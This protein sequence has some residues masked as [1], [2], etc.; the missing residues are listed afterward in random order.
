MED[1]GGRVVSL[2]PNKKD[3]PGIIQACQ[4]SRYEARK[5]FNF[6]IAR[7]GL[8]KLYRFLDVTND[9]L[10]LLNTRLSTVVLEEM[11]LSKG[12]Q[13]C[14]PSVT[15]LALDLAMAEEAMSQQ[16]ISANIVSISHLLLEMP[17]TQNRISGTCY[18]ISFPYSKSFM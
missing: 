5:K 1:I 9:I 10:L 15:R 2:E 14:L 16:R 6:C 17:L 7:Q 3:I 13:N 12:A 4:V 11:T 8:T 18:R